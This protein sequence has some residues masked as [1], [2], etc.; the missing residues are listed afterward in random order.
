MKRLGVVGGSE[1]KKSDPN[2]LWKRILCDLFC[3]IHSLKTP[4]PFYEIQ[5]SDMRAAER[6]I[7]MIATQI[8]FPVS[9]P[10]N[11]HKTLLPFLSNM[12]WSPSILILDTSI[13]VICYA[14]M[15]DPHVFVQR[16]P[17][18]PTHHLWMENIKN[19]FW[20][21]LSRKSLSIISSVREDVRWK[22]F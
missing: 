17:P 3:S 7:L 16:C 18:Q 11:F 19:F 2:V 22:N 6:P 12:E 8:V 15:I 14:T 21:F 9:L 13:F 5:I 1:G 10:W 4:P 20:G